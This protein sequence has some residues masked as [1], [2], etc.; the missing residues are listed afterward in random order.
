MGLPYR[1]GVTEGSIRPWAEMFAILLLLNDTISSAGSCIE[2]LH[3]TGGVLRLSSGFP[4]K[5]RSPS[6]LTDH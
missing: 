6:C 5:N 1:I 2:A 4:L 3:V